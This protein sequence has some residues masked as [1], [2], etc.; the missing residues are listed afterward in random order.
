MEFYQPRF[1]PYARY[2]GGGA[3]YQNHSPATMYLGGGAGLNQTGPSVR[4]TIV[5]RG[6]ANEYNTGR[7]T[8]NSAG[9]LIGYTV[10]NGPGPTQIA[11]HLNDPRTQA[12]YGYCLNRPIHWA[13][14]VRENIELFPERSSD[15][16]GE[17][18]LHDRWDVN[19]PEYHRLNVNPGQYLTIT[20]D[21]DCSE[22]SPPGGSGRRI[23][24]GPG[25]RTRRR[26]L[27]NGPSIDD[28]TDAIEWLWNTPA[29]RLIIPDMI[30]FGGGW[31]AMAGIGS[32][33]SV[34]FIWL[35]R[36]PEASY[37]PAITTTVALGAGFSIDATANFTVMSY[38]GPV[39]NLSREMFETNIAKGD[40]TYWASIGAAEGGKL[41]FTGSITPQANGHMII[42]R[43]L[44]LGAGLPMGPVPV[45]GAVGVSNTF[46]LHD[47][48]AQR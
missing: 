16:T 20:G 44:N 38:T 19:D 14:I 7:P 47:F 15:N 5:Q 46:I 30:S 10:G 24:G 3:T 18:F 27:P 36:G 48:G 21:C 29:M 35:L 22:P 1:N 37:L 43:E 11:A 32:S 39:D 8:V 42:G 40:V 41:G 28:I 34:E 25:R 2:L 4:L 9:K 17:G 23:V 12:R 13:Q 33:E 45:N 31:N 26:P 6:A